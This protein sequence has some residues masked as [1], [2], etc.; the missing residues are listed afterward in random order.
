[1][2]VSLVWNM[3]VPAAYRFLDSTQVAALQGFLFSGVVGSGV[4]AAAR[5]VS[6]EAPAKDD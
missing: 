5:K 1:M 3:A 2:F 6:G 4:T